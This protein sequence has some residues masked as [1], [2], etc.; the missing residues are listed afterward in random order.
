M[1]VTMAGTME[2]RMAT[3]MILVTTG[4]VMVAM[5]TTG[6][7]EGLSDRVPITR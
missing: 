3:S 7:T 5:I 2:T 1:I 6:T 4:T